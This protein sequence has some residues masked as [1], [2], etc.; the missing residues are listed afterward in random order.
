MAPTEG[1]R[2]LIKVRRALAADA[3]ATQGSLG[4]VETR[5]G[6]WAAGVDVS[7][8]SD[9]GVCRDCGKVGTREWLHPIAAASGYDAFRCPECATEQPAGASS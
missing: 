2:G 6:P 8:S 3:S 1:G 4:D 9:A 7:L 5:P